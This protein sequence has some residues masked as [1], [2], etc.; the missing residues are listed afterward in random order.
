MSRAFFRKALVAATLAAPGFLKLAAPGFLTLAA[1]AFLTLAAPA[2]AQAGSVT[3]IAPFAAGGP[4][5]VGAR[6]LADAMGRSMKTPV[7]VENIGGAGGN[8]GAARAA[9][10][11]PDGTTLLYTNISLAISPALYDQLA[12]DPARDFAAV[13]V[14]NF[15]TTMLL[16]RKDLPVRDVGEFIA[17]A[18]AKGLGVLMG[19]TGPG[20]PSDLCARLIMR[21][22]GAQFTLVSYK[23]TGPAMTDL[24]AGRLDVMCDSV[25]TA[26]AQTRA[27]T[28]KALG[29]TGTKRSI[30]Q[31]DTPTLDEQGLKGVDYKVWS[32]LFAP[33]KTPDDVLDR[34]HAGFVAALADP[35][36]RAVAEKLGQEIPSGD[37]ISRAGA[38]AFLRDEIALWGPLLKD[39]GKP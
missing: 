13:G 23:G 17:F 7:V 37:L 18:K 34:V 35:D 2:Y 20:G 9:R 11:N 19:N 27:G 14:T 32:G 1:P 15:A 38:D 33:R 3:M 25:V 30:F 29:V 31:P 4:T 5:D 16:A 12:Y 10:A 22:I 21:A 8:I 39:A 36:F 24:I 6:A 26:A 28:V